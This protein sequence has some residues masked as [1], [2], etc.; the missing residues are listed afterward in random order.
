MQWKT[1]HPKRQSKH[2]ECM[3]VFVCVG[4]CCEEDNTSAFFKALSWAQCAWDIY[5]KDAYKIHLK[6]PKSICNGT[7]FA[8][9]SWK[10]FNNFVCFV[11]FSLSLFHYLRS[12][13]CKIYLTRYVHSTWN[14]EYYIRTI[15]NSLI[16][17]A[18]CVVCLFIL[19]F[20]LCVYVIDTAT[21][22]MLFNC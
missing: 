13:S 11:Y 4:V 17:N 5:R 6:I 21:Y 16:G 3:C 10:T 20:F 7:L 9:F 14:S 1:Y 19:E 18:I 22:K 2:W 12:C 8:A 15:R